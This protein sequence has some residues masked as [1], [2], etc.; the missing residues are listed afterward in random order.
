MKTVLTYILLLCTLFMHFTTNAQEIDVAWALKTGNPPL[1]DQ[2]TMVTTL[3]N[4]YIVMAGEFTESFTIAGNTLATNGGNDIFILAFDPEG[5]LQQY[6]TL[7]STYDEYLEA[8]NSDSE[9]N[10]MLGISFYGTTI[11]GGETYTS[12]G[13]Q[14]I[15]LVSVDQELKP[16]WS[17]LIGGTKTDFA[18]CIEVTDNNDIYL[19]GYFNGTLQCNET[20]IEATHTSD[21]FIAR[22]NNTGIFSQFTQISGTATEKLYDL[23]VDEQNNLLLTGTFTDTLNIGS[24]TYTSPHQY[25]LF[26]AQI[27]SNNTL[28][29]C[30]LF[31]GNNLNTRAHL[32][33][34]GSHSV[35]T[36]DA[37]DTLWLNNTPL[38][39]N[40][41]FNQDIFLA[42]FNHQGQLQWSQN[43]GSSNTDEARGINCSKTGYITLTGHFRDNFTMGAIEL[44]YTMCCGSRDIFVGRITPQGEALWAVQLS[45]TKS[46][47]QNIST[48]EHTIA[49]TGGFSDTLRMPPHELISP[50]FT[51]YLALLTFEPW[52]TQN[53]VKQNIMLWPNPA[54]RHLNISGLSRHEAPLYIY[55]TM[56]QCIYS[57]PAT[58]VLD[59][60]HLPAG[61]YFI[62][63]NHHQWI[64]A[65][66]KK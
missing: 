41:Q 49:V 28:Q 26:L 2:H 22:F 5:S 44:E 36:G 4:G 20:V 55:N 35:I 66:I 45:G 16:R 18:T 42:Q 13:A 51:N 6:T 53:I 47:V 64:H 58:P 24:Q 29:W 50:Q 54:T 63:G 10:I 61:F 1:S 27:S 33:T 30:N 7:G 39:I 37:G 19:G 46:M 43:Y 17:Q 60:S 40:T 62:S 9:G 38:N 12:A 57:C 23:K 65:F 15:V 56:G 32:A 25:Q 8:I 3:P 34:D 48:G 11:I 14:D 21:I 59:I 31:H 52:Q